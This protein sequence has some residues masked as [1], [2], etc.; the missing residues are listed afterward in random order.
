MANLREHRRAA[1]IAR[2]RSIGSQSAL[3]GRGRRPRRKIER[4]L[5]RLVDRVTRRLRGASRAGRTVVLSLRFADYSRS[6]RS[7]TLPRAT[8]ATDPI[9]AA[10]Q[11]LLAEARPLIVERGITLVGVTITNLDDASAGIQLELPLYGSPTT[12]LDTAIDELRER[13]G[14]GSVIRGTGPGVRR[15]FFD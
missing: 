7:R 10:A 13:F 3:R 5:D 1:A 9:R 8:D 14:T 12:E 11:A 2:R 4:T 15:G 6:T